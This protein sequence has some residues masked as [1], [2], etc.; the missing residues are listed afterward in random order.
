MH[1]A[2]FVISKG[3]HSLLQRRCVTEALPRVH[4]GRLG[5][6]TL[7]EILQSHAFDVSATAMIL[8]SL[9]DTGRP[10]LWVSDRRSG[11]ESGHIY[12]AGLPALHVRTPILHVEVSHPRDVLQAME[13]GA[14]CTGLSAVVGEIHGTPRVLDFTATKRLALRAE[15]S[16]V[17]LWLIRSEDPQALTAARE[18]WRVSALPSATHLHDPQ[19]PG[20]AIWQ[21]ELFRTRTRPPGLWEVYHE[22]D[23]A[24][25]ADRLHLVSRPGNGSVEKIDSTISDL[26]RS[27]CAS[28]SFA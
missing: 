7:Q 20:H 11:R 14:T 26:A 23:A 6:A 12:L 4:S 25:P 1:E 10:L 27:R 15:T 3:G 19:A 21:A 9:G 28:G 16:G 24:D 13:E 2:R 17:P 5:E 22:P 8:V 18:R